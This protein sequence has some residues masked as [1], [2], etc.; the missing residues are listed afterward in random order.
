[1]T[2]RSGAGR[3]FFLGDGDHFEALPAANM[4]YL[5]STLDEAVKRGSKRC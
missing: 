4:A 1:M 5:R 2:K 3:D